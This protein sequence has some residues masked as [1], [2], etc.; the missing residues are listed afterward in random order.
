MPAS[1]TP[2]RTPGAQPR[3]RP[4]PP[5]AAAAH[6]LPHARGQAAAQLTLEC[7]QRARPD[8]AAARL[9]LSH[10]VGLA[11]PLAAALAPTQAP[12][13]A[14]AAALLRPRRRRT[15]GR[16][17]SHL[18]GRGGLQQVTPAAARPLALLLLLLLLLAGHDD[19][20]REVAGGER[21]NQAR[22]RWV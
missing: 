17:L 10:I 22:Q 16:R 21:G 5:R 12:A 15:G 4:P 18:Q 9:Q 3:P 11:A 7:Q 13:A 6:L 19:L 8:A 20:W 14:A 2:P 1:H